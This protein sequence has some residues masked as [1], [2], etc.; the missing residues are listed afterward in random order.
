MRKHIKQFQINHYKRADLRMHH[1]LQLAV[2][3]L[4]SP[5]NQS[6]IGVFIDVRSK[7]II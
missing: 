5:Y 6:K 2:M 4:K 7:Q 3:H 1:S